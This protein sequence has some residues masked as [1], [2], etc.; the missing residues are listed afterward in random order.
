MQW[1]DGADL[2]DY[3]YIRSEEVQSRGYRWD[4]PPTADRTCFYLNNNHYSQVNIESVS[5]EAEKEMQAVCQ[6]RR[7]ITNI[8]SK[9]Y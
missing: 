1:L 2:G 4:N 7:E 6:L 5:C 3:D 9:C 8:T